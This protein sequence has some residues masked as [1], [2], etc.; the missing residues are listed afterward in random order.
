VAAR[1]F[2]LVRAGESAYHSAMTLTTEQVERFVADGFVQLRAAFPR[3]LA[4]RGREILWRDVG[5]D[6]DD[7]STWTRP[8]V[9]LGGYADPP[10]RE[11]ANTPIL[12]G[13]LDQLVGAGRWAPLRGLGTFPVRF[14]SEHDPGDAGWHIDASFAAEGAD[15]NDIMAWRANIHSKGRSLLMLFL[16]SDVGEQDAPTRI[17]VGSHLDVARMLAPHGEA[18]V[19]VMAFGAGWADIG[20]ERAEVLATGE[21]GDVFLCHPLL[22]HS[23]QPHR[24]TR[25]RFMAQPPLFPTE[26]L[27]LDRPGGDYSP[28]ERAIRAAAC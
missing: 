14:P 7:P 20:R 5:A 8:V 1:D 16:F 2:G 9:R 11:A 23:A 18:G 19:S 6:P 24:G 22:L 27:R 25:P 28:V 26:P 3:E 13:A 12:R 10:F 17:R 21:A 4:D 15:P